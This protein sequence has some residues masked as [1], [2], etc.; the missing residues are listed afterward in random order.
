MGLVHLRR[1]VAAFAL[2]TLAAPA[3]RAQD[4][5]HPYTV[6]HVLRYATAEDIVGL[7]NHLNAQ[8]TLSFMSSLTMAWLL[9]F[10]R[11][12]KP[13]PELALAVPTQ[14]NHGISAD[15]KTITYHLR[16]DA[17]WSDGVPFTS[18]DVRFSA[19]VVLDSSNN[20]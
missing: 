6:P 20:E 16:K 4:A 1:I 19:N 3:V 5:R 18:D 17:K 15:G 14:A 10:D 9:K 7:N 12:N 8:G 13:I 2:V 11:E